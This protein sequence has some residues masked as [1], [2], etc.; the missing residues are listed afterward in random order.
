M[1]VWLLVYLSLILP[2]REHAAHYFLHRRIAGGNTFTAM[3]SHCRD[4]NRDTVPVLLSLCSVLQPMAV[5]SA[6][7]GGNAS[8]IVL[9]ADIGSGSGR[10]AHV[11]RRSRHETTSQ[12]SKHVGLCL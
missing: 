5:H 12:S 3:M 4:A 9:S 1:S 7:F 8:I 11:S 2:R 6:S 10:V